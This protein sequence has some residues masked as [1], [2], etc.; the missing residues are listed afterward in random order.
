MMSSGR[1]VHRAGAMVLSV[2]MAVIG[3]VLVVQALSSHAA[4]SGRLLL[5]VLFGAAG[6]GR[7]YVE[8]RRGRRA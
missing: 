4:L 7:L 3:I 2:A 8:V 5:G 6:A 1:Q